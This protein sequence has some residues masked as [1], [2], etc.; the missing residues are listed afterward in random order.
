MIAPPDGNGRP[1]LVSGL[2]TVGHAGDD[3][4]LWIGL[5][6]GHR[7]QVFGAMTW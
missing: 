2:E 4:M 5:E 3:G 1:I 7:Q 6:G